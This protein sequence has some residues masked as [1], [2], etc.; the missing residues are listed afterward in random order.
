MWIHACGD[1]GDLS[2]P[3]QHVVDR[4]QMGIGLAALG[5]VREASSAGK[6]T[7]RAAGAAWRRS[8]PLPTRR[9][10]ALPGLECLATNL[11][12]RPPRRR[13]G[14][15]RGCHTADTCGLRQRETPAIVGNVPIIRCRSD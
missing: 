7:V 9:H 11:L 2:R 8:A 10:G 1:G 14:R 15:R 12:P 4:E 13:I 6:P 3:A 5:S